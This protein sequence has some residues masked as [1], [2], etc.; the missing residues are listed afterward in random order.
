LIYKEHDKNRSESLSVTMIDKGRDHWIRKSYINNDL[1]GLLENTSFVILPGEGFRDHSGPVFPVGTEEL[2]QFMK[3]NAPGDFTV[4]FAVDDDN[5]HELALHS[6]ILIIGGFLVTAVAAPVGVKLIEKYID[7]RL[8]SAKNESNVRVE[9]KIEQGDKTASISYEGPA[10]NF[11]SIVGDAVRNL[12]LE[13]SDE[14]PA[15]SDGSN[16]GQ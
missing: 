12:S 13:R 3:E 14:I 7:K 16:D 11:Q 1:Y 4:E 5:Y 6:L 10:E 9:F 8:G 15:L 2:Y